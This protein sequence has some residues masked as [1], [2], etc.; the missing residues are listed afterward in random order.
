MLTWRCLSEFSALGPGFLGRKGPIVLAPVLAAVKV[1]P[2][3]PVCLPLAMLRLCC[4][5][6]MLMRAQA[7]CGR[8][9]VPN[10]AAGGCRARWW[11]ERW[12]PA[13]MATT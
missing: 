12:R 5:A 9:D 4:I 3:P 2:S 7:L 10:A 11:H 6:L 8:A 1:A 13:Q